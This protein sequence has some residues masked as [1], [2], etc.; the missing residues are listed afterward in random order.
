MTSLRRLVFALFYFAAAIIASALTPSAAYAQTKPPEAPATAPTTPPPH[1]FSG[2][3]TVGLSL[4][5]GRT[6]LTGVQL[7]LEAKRPY[8]TAGSIDMSFTYAHAA[9]DPPGNTGR[10][11]VADR[12]TATFD[13]EQNFRKRL[14]MM[15]RAEALRDPISHIRYRIGE[16]AGF[17][18]RLGDKRR[19][20]RILPG[21]AFLSDDKLSVEDGFKV[22]YGLY[23]DIEA[24]ITPT[25]TFAQV[26]SVSR[27]VSD[28]HDYIAAINARLTGAVTRRLSIQLS[29]QYNY[30]KRLP[31]GVDPRYQKT[32]AGLQIN[33]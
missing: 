9:T 8:S 20:I 25:W 1:T 6:D 27:N 12:L 15:L 26:L 22:H 3:A 14:V 31:P 21:V 29:Y 24:T 33:F 4:E 28:P 18:V 19:Q 30:E 2:S 7:Q 13:V 17:G 11:T 32:A 10:V 5:S 16:M 23:E